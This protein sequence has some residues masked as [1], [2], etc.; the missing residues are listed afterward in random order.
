MALRIYMVVNARAKGLCIL[1]LVALEDRGV[2][3]QT[4]PAINYLSRRLIFRQG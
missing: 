4:V 1:S 3:Q 2:A